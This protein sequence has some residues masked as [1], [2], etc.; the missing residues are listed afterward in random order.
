LV[1]SPEFPHWDL[2]V[3]ALVFYLEVGLSC[4]GTGTVSTL[5]PFILAVI[6]LNFITLN[7]RSIV[8]SFLP[9]ELQITL[10]RIN[11]RSRSRNLRWSTGSLDFIGSL[12][13]VTPS[14]FVAASNLVVHKLRGKER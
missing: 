6:D 3:D 9:L 14:P 4:H 11:S 2:T 12:R 7:G 13:E 8:S 1:L 10:L 5:Y